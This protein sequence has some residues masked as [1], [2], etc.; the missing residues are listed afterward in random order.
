MRIVIDD[1]IPFIKGVLESVAEVIY[2]PS[3]LINSK[4]IVD[5]DALII[6]TRTICNKELLKNSKVKF[7]AT[8]T[9][10]YDHIDTQYCQENNI[11]WVNAPGC[12][13]ESVNQYICSAI[14]KLSL[15]LNFDF[16]KMIL[17]IVGVGNVGSKVLASTTK[18]GMNVLACDP[19]RA[20]RETS[21]H[22]I[23]YEQILKE[24]DI[25]TYHTPLIDDGLYPTKYMFNESSIS[26]LKNTA[27]II[28]TSRGSVVSNDSLKCALNENKIQAAVLDVWENEPD[29][30]LEL[31]E[32]VNYATPHIAGY[33]SDGKYKATLMSLNSL[34][35]FFNLE[36]FKDE[37]IGK[38]EKPI[39]PLNRTIDL[40][41]NNMSNLEKWLKVFL[42]SYDISKDSVQFK[43]KPELFESFRNNYTRDRRE[44]SAYNIIGE[45][46]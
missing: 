41:L 37:L 26:Y 16:T 6:R 30:D 29:I 19:P 25:I 27:I 33:S 20:D 42:T 14:V 21:F 1:K 7:I 36:K 38:L 44:L 31:L 34:L 22:S 45:L 32:K 9:I 4:N 5:V 24:S 17:G 43:S 15:D 39:A 28:N 3:F 46:N 10:G 35:D 13:S 8:A 18:M 12:N 11:S 40:T 2:L 23:S